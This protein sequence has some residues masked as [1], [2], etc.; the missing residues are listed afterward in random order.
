MPKKSVFW[1]WIVLIGLGI[2]GAGVG[3]Y[4]SGFAGGGAGCITGLF[5]GVCIVMIATPLEPPER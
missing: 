2:A 4:F 1:M 5:L 3:T